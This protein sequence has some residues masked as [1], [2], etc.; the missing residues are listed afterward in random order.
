MSLSASI[1]EES[2]NCPLDLMSLARFNVPFVLVP[3]FGLSLCMSQFSLLYSFIV[4][5]ESSISS[6]KKK[7]KKPYLLLSSGPII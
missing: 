1:T 2:R 5:D 7:K 3:V 6:K 4:H